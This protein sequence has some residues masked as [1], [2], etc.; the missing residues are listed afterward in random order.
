MSRYTKLAVL[1]LLTVLSGAA[2]WHGGWATITVENLPDQLTVGTPYNLTFSVRQHGDNLL[3]DL[4]PYLELKSKNG[5]SKVRA[6]ATRKPGFYT[7]TLNVPEPGDWSVNIESSFGRSHQQLMPI[8]AVP[9]GARPVSFSPAE[10]GHRL[11]VAKGCAMCHSHAK[12]EAYGKGEVGP[13]LTD[14]RFATQYLRQYL[15]NPTIKPPTTNT[16]MPDLGLSEAEITALVA[17]INSEAPVRT[18]QKQK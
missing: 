9:G 17:F 13:E 12:A 16:R 7:A 3:T 10:R 15:A 11:F 6:V 4:S 18:A 8:A 14:K 5:E 2:T 1:A